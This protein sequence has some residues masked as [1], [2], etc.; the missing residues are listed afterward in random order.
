MHYARKVSGKVQHVEAAYD[1]IYNACDRPDT[2][3]ETGA[4]M[5]HVYSLDKSHRAKLLHGSWKVEGFPIIYW[6]YCHCT[7]TIAPRTLLAP[8]MSVSAN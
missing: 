4:M 6:R 1:D 2:R 8:R 7:V 3:D 5:H